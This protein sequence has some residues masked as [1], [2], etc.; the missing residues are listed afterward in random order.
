MNTFV[1]ISNP[2]FFV[3]L[4]SVFQDSE[5]IEKVSRRMQELEVVENNIKVLTEMLA[6]YSPGSA[7][8]SEKDIMKV[9]LVTH[10][11]FIKISLL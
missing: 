7:N 8:Q 6:Y 9:Q 10:I 3:I 1:N 4:L 5:R 11:T 2:F